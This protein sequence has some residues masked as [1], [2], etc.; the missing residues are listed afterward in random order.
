M[1]TQ[2]LATPKTLDN[3]RGPRL[4]ERLGA[5]T[6]VLAFV[7][8]VC[9]IAVSAATG[10][11][12]ANPGATA[13]QLARAYATS[14]SPPVWLGAMLQM[15]AFVCLFGFATYL[16][17][18][19]AAGGTRGDWLDALAIG[20][21]Q[22]FVALTVAGFAIGGVARFRAGPELDVSVAM[23]LFDIH[24][25][26]YVA[27]WTLGAV[28]MLAAAALGLQSRVLPSWLSVAAA[29]TAVVSVA[30]VAFPTTPLAALPSL[31]IWFWTLAASLTLYMTVHARTHDF[32]VGHSPLPARDAT[33]EPR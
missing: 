23:A 29:L 9:G 25:A 8:A 22:A 12:A 14:P 31:L 11:K 19:L 28:W 2:E 13:E 20:A 10:T 5:A 3:W 1:T 33:G 4:L 16:A 24:V 21:G 30:A 32:P 27:S 17:R 7:L 6:G 26:L 15:I 18:A